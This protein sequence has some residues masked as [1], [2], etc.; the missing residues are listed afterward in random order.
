MQNASAVR[1]AAHAG[2]GN[3]HHIADTFFEQFLRDRK[4]APFRHAGTS[5]RTCVLQHD[6]RIL[7]DIEIDVVNSHSHVVVILEYD[8]RPLVLMQMLFRS[9]VFN[10][11]AVGR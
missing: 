10:D 11:R 2:V 3:A 6:D 7:G 9:G 1:C 5:D 4:L 8:G